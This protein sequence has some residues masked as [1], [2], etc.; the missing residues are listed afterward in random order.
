MALVS[1]AAGEVR[2]AGEVCMTSGWG[3][4]SSWMP[5]SPLGIHEEEL[6]PY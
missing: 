6:S 4:G 2:Q 3:L 1:K 5:P